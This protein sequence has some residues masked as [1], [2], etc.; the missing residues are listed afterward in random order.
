M[1]TIQ[2][3]PLR[4]RA[5]TYQHFPSILLVQFLSDACFIVFA[6]PA[7]T[8]GRDIDAVWSD[9][10]LELAGLVLGRSHGWLN[11]RFLFLKIRCIVILDEDYD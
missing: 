1:R 7:V 11:I 9:I 2:S 5:P 6:G 8:Y 3:L 4:L 10:P